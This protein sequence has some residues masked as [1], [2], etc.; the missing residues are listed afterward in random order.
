[1]GWIMPLLGACI[2]PHPP[3]IIPQVGRGEQEKIGETVAAYKKAGEYVAGL[4]PETV[5]V[6]TPHSVLYGDYLHLSPGRR[7]RG[8]FGR[9][10]AKDVS[11]EKEYDTEL[12]G[13]LCELAG[14]R[15]IAAGTLGERDP[16]IDHGALIPLYFIDKYLQDYRIVRA[17]ISGLPALAHYRFGRC[18]ADAAERLG[19]KIAVVAS[20]DLS[21]KLREDG[22]YGF[23]KEGPAFDAQLTGAM[24]EGDFSRFLAISGGFAEAAAE[25]GLRSF[26]E[27]AGALDGFA[28]KPEFLS[29]QGPFGVGYAVCLYRPAGRDDKRRFGERY[30]REQEGRLADIR[31]NEDEYVRL[32]R[33]SL[34]YYVKNRRT[35]K[36]PED[37]CDPLLNEKAGVFVSLKKDGKLR[38][39]IG[40][41]SAMQA[42]VADEIIHNAISA[43]AHDPRFGAVTEDELNALVYSVDVLGRPEKV[44]GMDALDAKRYGVI[45]TKGARQGLLLPNLEGVDTPEEQ[46]RIAMQKAC[47]PDFNG[48]ALQRFE[49]VRHK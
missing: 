17:S 48:C 44:R 7:A 29:Y 24:K 18:I 41:I 28:V 6:I 42:S 21:H 9:F 25:C 13:A 26:I 16:A 46:V 49:V 33:A 11:I 5:V 14:E 37:L 27:M 8:D 34:E 20:G 30:V 1:M 19:R 15:G 31:K 12:V 22:P 35:L 43:G 45:V 4:A 38:G 39:C 47:I 10:G 23:A 36:R 2:V 32:A 40:T 3:L